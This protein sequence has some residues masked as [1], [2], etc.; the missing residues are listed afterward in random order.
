[1]AESQ[2]T[3]QLIFNKPRDA[4]KSTAVN[5]LITAAEIGGGKTSVKSG[6]LINKLAYTRSVPTMQRGGKQ[7]FL[8]EPTLVSSKTIRVWQQRTG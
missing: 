3:S 2:D 7:A 6:C 8:Y 1:M 4:G 5:Q